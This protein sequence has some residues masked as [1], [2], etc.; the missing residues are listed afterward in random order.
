MPT[1]DKNKN[2]VKLNQCRYAMLFTAP[3]KEKGGCGKSVGTALLGMY[4]ISKVNYR[5]ASIPI[6]QSDILLI[7]KN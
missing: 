2:K 7:M 5:C 1:A 3:S 4:K 6:A